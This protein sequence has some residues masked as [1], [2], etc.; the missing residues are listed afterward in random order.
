M[1]DQTAD[2]NVEPTADDRADQHEP[3]IR[4]PG[5][6]RLG[7]QEFV[8]MLGGVRGVAEST[9]AGV[10]FA[11]VYAVSRQNLTVALWAAV[12]SGLAV[13]LVSLVQR[14]TV[15]QALA[16]FV[17]IAIMAGVAR[18][19]G[20]ASDFYLP[21]LLKNGAYAAAYIVSILVR[22][23]LIGV[24]LGPILG[25]GTAWRRDP[26][27][28]RAYVMVSWLWAGMFLLRL[29]IQIPLY[30]ADEVT[31]LGL[32]GIPLGL[33]LFLLVCW[34]SFVIL[35]RVPVARPTSTQDDASTDGAART[36]DDASTDDAGT[37]DD[38][39]ETGE[40]VSGPRE[41]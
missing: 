39:G 38:A 28:M 32:A 12:L 21:S 26:A 30:L 15:R 24:V 10:V 27:R 18:F 25:E 35:V 41:G 36:D 23:P 9:I 8:D 29:A 19:T 22:W 2:P 6:S 16:G 1:A 7:Q 31:W 37:G 5:G 33:P 17:G 3:G 4:L 11:I 14:R 40:S 13:V 34:L 20:S